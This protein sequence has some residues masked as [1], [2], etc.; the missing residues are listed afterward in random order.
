MSVAPI[1]ISFIDTLKV[2]RYVTVMMLNA[3]GSF[4]LP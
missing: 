2:T 4:V 1:G 3:V